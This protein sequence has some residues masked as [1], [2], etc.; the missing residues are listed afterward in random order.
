MTAIPEAPKNLD[1]EEVAKR[2]R[3]VKNSEDF[4]VAKEYAEAIDLLKKAYS[5]VKTREEKA[6]ISRRLAE[7]YKF[8]FSYKAAEAQYKRAIKLKQVLADNYLGVAEMLK[9]QGEYI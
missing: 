8:T 7:S 2:P 1:K 4:F 6:E 5:K 9:Y 3:V